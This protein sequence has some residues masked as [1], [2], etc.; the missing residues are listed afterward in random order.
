[1]KVLTSNFAFLKYICSPM[2]GIAS[3]SLKF[4]A[5]SYLMFLVQTNSLNIY[6]ERMGIH[7]LEQSLLHHRPGVNEMG[8]V[9]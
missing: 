2:T 7:F 4:R 3:S 6:R 1:M 8:F 9:I 5:L